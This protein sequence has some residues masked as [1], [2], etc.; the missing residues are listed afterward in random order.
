MQQASDEKEFV[1]LIV[2]FKC[3]KII[4]EKA[5][6]NHDEHIIIL[7]SRILNMSSGWITC[8]HSFWWSTLVPNEVH[9]GGLEGTVNTPYLTPWMFPYPPWAGRME[10]NK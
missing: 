2:F 6:P 1:Y 5:Q 10:R 7:Y 4:F 8:G 3:R 9:K